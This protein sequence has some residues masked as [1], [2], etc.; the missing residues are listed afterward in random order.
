MRKLHSKCLK[1]VIP[2]DTAGQVKH[3]ENKKI[4]LPITILFV[5]W[6]S[7]IVSKKERKAKVFLCQFLNEDL[8]FMCTYFRA[9]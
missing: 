2:G 7:I 1:M 8:I 6:A 4:P 5:I 9:Y 3:R